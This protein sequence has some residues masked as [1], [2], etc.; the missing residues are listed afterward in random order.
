MELVDIFNFLLSILG[1]LWCF[2]PFPIGFLALVG[3]SD[4]I[5]P[6]ERIQLLLFCL[7]WAVM[8]PIK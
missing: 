2:A 5:T 7:I 8:F 6:L 3:K 1:V 4:T